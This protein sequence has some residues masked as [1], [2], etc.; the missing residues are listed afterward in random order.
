[1]FNSIK[2]LVL[3]LDKKQRKKLYILQILIIFMSLLEILGIVSIVPF[4]KIVADP[5]LLENSRIFSYFYTLSNVESTYD[6]LFIIG[7]LVLFI[8][9]ISSVLSIYTTWKLLSFG[10]RTGMEIGDK[11]YAYYMSQPWL[12]HVSTNSSLLTK[13]ISQEAIRVTSEMI[14]PL[15]QLN[16]KIILLIFLIITI[17]FFEPYVAL[18]GFIIFVLAYISMYR[19]VKEKVYRNGVIITS[20]A[21]DRFKLMNEGFGGIKD[22]ILLGKKDVFIAKFSSAGD[23]Y[24]KSH[25]T[26]LSLIKTPRY[27][28]EFIA[29][30]SF[31]FLIL[32][33]IMAKGGDLSKI[34][35]LLSVYAL[36]GL[37]ILPATQQIYTHITTIKGA[38]PAFN[39]I[40]KDLYDSRATSNN[41][42]S[43]SN[44]SFPKQNIILDKISFTYPNK[45]ISAL[46][47][48]CIEIPVNKVIGIVGTSGSGKSTVIDILLGLLKSDAGD[49]LA[50]GIPI[51]GEQ[52]RN[53]Q[54]N[55]GYVPQSIFLL[56]G[57]IAENIAF[58]VDIE[59]IDMKKVKRVVETVHLNELVDE[60]PD[61]ILSQVGE[62]GVQLSGGQRQRIGIARA[63]YYDADLLVFD[64]ATSALDGITE[65]LIMNAIHEFSGKKTIVLIA[66]RLKTIEKCDIIY[67][68]DKGRVVDSGTYLE[69]IEKNQDFK[70]MALHA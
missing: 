23:K 62:Q 28:V 22:T 3:L 15:L 34:L 47:E 50:D 20:T 13:Q 48:V 33:L 60:L 44:F 61:G 58:G 41:N 27:F 40:K 1:M 25:S 56:D 53:W 9:S 52:V 30:S 26:N 42:A 6:F 5:T 64:E 14:L 63:L 66:H 36:A 69:L 18:F 51:N 65:K 31:I 43:T 35:P 55:I 38:L 12:F 46:Q 2:E 39:T 7:L 10:S 67:I 24:A 70:K 45:K 68:L 8:I 59:E 21:K 16:A 49:I 57:S 54:K 32:Y 37:K 4:M 29:I 19:I 11:L 17:F